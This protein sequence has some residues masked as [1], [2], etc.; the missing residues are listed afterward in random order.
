MNIKARALGL[1]LGTASMLVLH[2]SP[3]VAQSLLEE[4]TTLG[5][6]AAPVERVFTLAAAGDY[7]VRLTDFGQPANFVSLRL[8]VTRGLEIVR[9]VDAPGT[10][11]LTTTA[12]AHEVHVIGVPGAGSSAG[13]FGVRILESD[14][15]IAE[16]QFAGS[17][18]APGACEFADTITLAAPPTPNV[19]TLEASFDLAEAGSYQLDLSDVA[20]PSALQNVQFNI[21]APGGGLVFPAPGPSGPG[22]YSFTGVAGTYEL[23]LVAE[24]SAA[25]SAG[26]CSV[27]ISGGPSAAVIYEHS[28]PVA[29]VAAPV[30]IDLSATGT[31][32]LRLTDFDAPVALTRLAGILMRGAAQLARR[33]GAGSESFNASAGEV[34]LFLLATPASGPGSGTI[35]IDVLNGATAAYT[36]ARTVTLATGATMPGF[37]FS[38]DIVAAGSHRLTVTDFDFPAAFDSLT[39]HVIQG[40]AVLGTIG[41]DDELDVDAAAGK[42]FV[43]VI[44]DPAAASNGL[45]ALQLTPP[46]G[47]APLFDVSQGVGSLFELHA[48]DVAQAGSQDVQLADLEF[49]ARFGS[50]AVAVTRGAARVG[51]I[52]GGGTFS[53]AATPGRYFLSVIAEPAAQSDAGTYG[54]LVSPTPPAPTVTLT[55]GAASVSN[56]GTTSLTWSSTDATSC[57]ASGAWSG[58]KPTSGTETTP[59][60]T[61]GSSFTL[62]CSGPGGSASQSVTVNVSAPTSSDGGGG[63]LGLVTLLLALTGVIRRYSTSSP[64][65]QNR[66]IRAHP[67]GSLEARPRPRSRLSLRAHMM[68]STKKR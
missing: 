13:I 2:C 12:G 53:F 3:A 57:T 25:A 61:S 36:A 14:G 26:L 11:P 40:G 7:Q 29:Q 68:P 5:R 42:I 38:A 46:G 23:L 17:G 49:P 35:G 47:G 58:N 59:A 62:T 55:A 51:S 65:Q 66:A 45:F 52:F 48:V 24:A 64:G 30:D 20:F 18:A 8:I 56:G 63:S 19:A 15:S 34:Q 10:Q 33:D 44:A 9:T 28:H 54:L 31:Y 27:R 32:T 4:V 22:S 1:L 50:I 43:T 60:L 6:G 16:C 67:G 41:A 21:L 39:A 37:T